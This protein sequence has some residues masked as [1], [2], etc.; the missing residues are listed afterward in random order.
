MND[1]NNNKVN[2][3]IPETIRVIEIILITM[4]MTL[5]ERMWSCR[6]LDEGLHW[7]SSI[8]GA[9]GIALTIGFVPNHAFGVPPIDS[10]INDKYTFFTIGVI[11]ITII[12]MIIIHL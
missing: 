5:T 6:V 9:L 4:R 1:N 12:T 11:I 10:M 2:V 7:V 8:I 3:R